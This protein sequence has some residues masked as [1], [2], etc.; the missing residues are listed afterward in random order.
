MKTKRSSNYKK[1]DQARRAGRFNVDLSAPMIFC[2]VEAIILL[3]LSVILYSV[4]LSESNERTVTYLLIALLVS[5]VISAG[6]ICLFYFIK[7][8]RVKRAKLVSK[9]FETEIYDVFRYI[10]DLPYAVIDRNGKV[11]VMNGA[12][13]DILGYKNAVSGIDVSEFCSVKFGVIS[14]SAKNRETYL[15]DPIYSLP[16]DSEVPEMPITRLAD[17]RRYRVIPYIFKNKDQNYYFTVFKDVEELLS[18]IEREERE[19]TV[20]AYIILDN[21]QELTQYVRADYRQA[22][23]EIENILRSWVIEMKGFIREY[24]NDK[25]IAVF[26]KQELDRQMLRDFDIQ[27]TIMSLR[28]GDNSFPVTVSMGIA[29]INGT[30]SEKEKAA[31]E[32]LNIA[33]KRGGNQVAIRRQDSEDYVYFGGTHKTMENNTAVI[34]R[35]SGEILEKEIRSADRVLIMGHSNPDFD[36]IGSCV[37]MARF[38]MEVLSDEHRSRPPEMIPQ[39]NIVTNKSVESFKTCYAQLEPLGAYKDV[40]ITKDDALDLVTASTVLILCDVSNPQIFESRDLAQSVS[41]VAILDHHRLASAL[42]F[43]PFLQYVEATKSSAS[44]IVAEILFRSKYA[45]ALHKEEAEVLLSG[46]MLDTNNFTRNAGAQTFEITHYLYSRGAHTGVVREFFDESLEEL[47]LT[48]EFESKVKIIRGCVALT[49]M[50]LDRPTTPQDRIV[51][52]KV[53]DKLLNVKGVEASFALIKMD[54]DVVISGRSRGDINVQL[55][56]ERLKGGGHFDIAGAQVKK[57]SI[58][59]SLLMLCAAI[60][61]YF[62]FDHKTESKK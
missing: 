52:S 2:T 41:K 26:S 62:E 17:G 27:Q 39:V 1:A 51:A 5:Y 35:V 54:S 33:I 9:Q 28:I 50:S 56:L 14:A 57:S 43:E 24:E 19:S 45:S 46:I 53:A 60:D 20:V 32:A 34:S 11:K 44:E 30:Y 25:Y 48:G 55:I 58:G 13:L 21:L 23:T 4:F 18:T 61:D 3:A 10:I 49:W 7:S 42:T 16:G 22:S 31:F 6:L 36:A 15:D 37:G 29:A 47:M 12:L 40:F 38:A 8:R 59:D